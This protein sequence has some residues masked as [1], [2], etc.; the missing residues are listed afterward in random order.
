MLLTESLVHEIS[1]VNI[2]QLFLGDSCEILKVST[3]TTTEREAVVFHRK[4]RQRNCPFLKQKCVG[5]F[6]ILDLEH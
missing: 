6:L 1:N 2:W 4:Q 5:F 3:Q